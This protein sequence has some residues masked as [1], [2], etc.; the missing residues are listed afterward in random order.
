MIKLNDNV[1]DNLSK[2]F[3]YSALPERYRVMERTFEIQEDDI[4]IDGGAYQGDMAIYFSLKVPKGLVY[5]F[6]PFTINRLGILNLI[7]KYNLY[8]VRL[9]PY[10][11]WDKNEYIPFYLSDY[12]NACSPLKEFRKVNP[13]KKITVMSGTLDRIVSFFEIPKVNHIW[14]NIEGSEVKAI[15]GAKD[16]LKNND[17]DIIVSTHKINEKHSTTE[18]VIKLLEDYGFN[19][20]PIK[21]HKMW[22]YG[23]K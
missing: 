9:L 12:N 23:W 7:A 16:T 19:T 8:N 21:S 5:S 3:N 6:E 17:C 22:I 10:A 18:D 4:I 2:L 14:L 15:E 1:L 11:L 20:R 13:K